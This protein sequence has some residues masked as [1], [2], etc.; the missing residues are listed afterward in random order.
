MSDTMNLVNAVEEV[1]EKL[2]SKEYKEILDSAMKIHNASSNNNDRNNLDVHAGIHEVYV[3]ALHTIME[4]IGGYSMRGFMSAARPSR[5]PGLVE[6][7]VSD[8]EE[9]HKHKKLYL[10]R[11]DWYYSYVSGYVDTFD[12][13]GL[14]EEAKIDDTH[15]R[16]LYY[17]YLYRWDEIPQ[18]YEKR[19]YDLFVW[20]QW[21]DGSYD[22]CNSSEY[23]D[24]YTIDELWDMMNKYREQHYLTYDF[25]EA[26][27]VY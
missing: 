6:N 12:F 1:K 23:T 2:S 26:I 16:A 18:E 22:E 8:I 5:V 4:G 15:L 11:Q 19:L 14:I 27:S 9:L 21:E 17:I 3:E 24:H 20:Y 25:L 13:E 10:A 7:M